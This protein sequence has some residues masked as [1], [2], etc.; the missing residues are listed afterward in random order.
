MT[1]SRTAP[2]LD[3][4]ATQY[5]N[6]RG[7]CGSC[8]QRRRRLGAALPASTRRTVQ[9]HLSASVGEPDQCWRWTGFIGSQ[10]YGY[11]AGGGRFC[12][13]HRRA[14]EHW[15][16]PIP[17][18][19]E[20]D[21]RCHTDD[22]ECFEGDLCP[23][24]AC[25]NPAHLELVT[26]EQNVQR[27]HRA[28]QEQCSRG[29]EL[30]GENIYQHRGKRYCRQCRTEGQQ[31]R[32]RANGAKPMARMGET[33]PA[34]H[35]LDEVNLHITPGGRKICR[36]CRRDRKVSRRRRLGVPEK[37]TIGTHCPSGHE[38]T[39]DNLRFTKVGTKYCYPCQREAKRKWR[40]RMKAEGKT[41]T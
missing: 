7:L 9:F 33:C 14:Y 15:V 16:G 30:S 24:R 36:T 38:M 26:H 35:A 21:H 20:I 37:K 27:A 32:A 1:G 17:D 2:C 29:H 31:R 18:G 10:G 34:G 3:C 22:P 8:Y 23:H 39:P 40:L 25:V 6:R 28:A 13:A 11:H 12:S 4:G 41:P 19:M 5:T